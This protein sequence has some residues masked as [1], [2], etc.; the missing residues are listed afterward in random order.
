M[1]TVRKVEKELRIPDLPMFLNSPMAADVTALYH[2]HRYEHRP[3]DAQ[4]RLM[5]QSARIVNSE[6]GRCS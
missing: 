5:R 4:C 2:R 6:E 1:I 3:D